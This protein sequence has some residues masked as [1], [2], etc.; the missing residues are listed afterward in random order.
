MQQN[1]Q[2]LERGSWLQTVS[3]SACFR[4]GVAI[5][6][7]PLH[8]RATM[9]P[10]EALQKAEAWQEPTPAPGEE[11]HRVTPRESIKVGNLKLS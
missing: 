9:L 11:Q 5:N 1:S 2:A 4:L 6:D 7:E 10:A 3:L 8:S